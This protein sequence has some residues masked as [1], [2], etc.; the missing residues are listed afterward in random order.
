MSSKNGKKSS[1]ATPLALFLGGLIF[2]AIV[3]NWWNPTNFNPFGYWNVGNGIPTELLLVMCVVAPFI[4]GQL[5]WF[6]PRTDTAI[7]RMF[8]ISNIWQWVNKMRASL[9]AGVFEELSFRSVMIYGAMVSIALMNKFFNWALAAVLLVICIALIVMTE[10]KWL[11]WVIGILGL[12]T[13]FWVTNHTSSD[14]IYT[15]YREWYQPIYQAL[16]DIA[17]RQEVFYLILAVGVLDILLAIGTK[18]FVKW[19]APKSRNYTLYALDEALSPRML[20]TMSLLTLGLSVYIWWM[21][22][23]TNAVMIFGKPELLVWGI[24]SCAI[25]FQKAHGSQPFTGA[26]HKVA[27]AYFMMYIAFTFGLMY[28]IIGH[29]LYDAVYFTSEH[30]VYVV[31]QRFQRE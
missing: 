14:P 4:L 28:A 31:N 6:N 18:L 10:Q 24:I 12:V 21:V 19:R 9:Y 30:I 16:F 27:F 8:G 23:Y 1:N 26:L 15:F 22:T 3:H 11:K 17:N 29:A 2:Y 5:H 20:F 13:F 25:D 7:D